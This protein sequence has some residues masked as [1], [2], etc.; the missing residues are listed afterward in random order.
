MNPKLGTFLISNHH[1]NDDSAFTYIVGVQLYLCQCPQHT[2][3][4]FMGSVCHALAHP[5]SSDIPALLQVPCL[6]S[7]RGDCLPCHCHDSKLSG[8]NINH[9]ENN[10]FFK[11][12]LC[13]WHTNW[14]F[15]C[16]GRDQ[17]SLEI[18]S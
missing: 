1:N 12:G 5:H 9:P 8:I 14:H 4:Q 2:V 18:R 11:G 15:L 16:C 3:L 10:T 13:V 7:L 17:R 6:R